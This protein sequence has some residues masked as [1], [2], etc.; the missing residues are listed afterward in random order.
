MIKFANTSNR[1]RLCLFCK[2]ETQF[3]SHTKCTVRVSTRF[4]TSLLVVG[5]STVAA[6]IKKGT[7]IIP[8]TICHYRL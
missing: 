8:P 7:M 2:N 3:N 5:T 1:G 6:A 4:T